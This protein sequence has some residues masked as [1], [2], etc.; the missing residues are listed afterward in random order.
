VTFFNDVHVMG[1]VMGWGGSGDCSDV[2]SDVD[3][4]VIR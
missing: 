1:D 4:D 3:S 2:D